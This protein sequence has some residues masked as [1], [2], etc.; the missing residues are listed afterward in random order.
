MKL[1]NYN[2]HSHT[3]RCGHAAFVGDLEYIHKYIDSK[4]YNYFS[5]VHLNF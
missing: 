1:P 4:L 2:Y 3:Y 5:L